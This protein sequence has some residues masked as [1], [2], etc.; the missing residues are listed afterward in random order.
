MVGIGVTVAVGVAV[1]VGDGVHVGGSALPPP[2]IVEVGLASV[3]S[4]VPITFGPASGCSKIPAT[5]S[6]PLITIKN[7]APRTMIPMTM[8]RINPFQ[9]RFG[10]S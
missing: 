1:E 10:P 3:V 9:F 2:S 4:V 5:K 6:I 7:P 8:F